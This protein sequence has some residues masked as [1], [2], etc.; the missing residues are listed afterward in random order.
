MTEMTRLIQDEAVQKALVPSRLIPVMEQVFRDVSGGT[1]KML[2]RV[3]LF[4]TNGNIFAVMA[5]SLPSF[6]VCGCK[7]AIFPGPATAAANTQQSVVLLFDLET[8]ALKGVVSAEHITVARTAAA[9]AAATHTLALPDASVLCLLGAGNQALGHARAICT[10][11]PIRE[12]RIWDV[13]PARART[14]CATLNGEG[15]GLVRTT[16]TAEEAVRGAQ[17]I[18]TVSKAQEPILYGDWLMPGAHVNA[19][20]ACSPLARELDLS[21]LK[22]GQVYVDQRQAVLESAGDLLIPMK[23]GLY[24]EQ[25]ITGEIGEVLNGTCPGRAQGDRET[26]TVYET[27]GLAAQDVAAAYA[28]LQ[29]TPDTATF[30][31]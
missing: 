19:V 2:P 17:I 28:V 30:R 14:A 26:V 5:A 18:C 25:E 22:R 13:D 31:F 8:G 6:G 12:I 24:D 20:G 23:A 11:R 7:S 4:H 29:N 27:T 1:L 3:A 15:L 9:T 16:A 10:I 21:V